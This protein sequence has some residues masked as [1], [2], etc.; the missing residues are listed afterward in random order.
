MPNA[1]IPAALDAQLDAELQRL[2]PLSLPEAIEHLRGILQETWGPPSDAKMQA[3][4]FV[5]RYDLQQ[6]RHG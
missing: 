3:Q 4:T 6:V 2:V 5:A 1:T